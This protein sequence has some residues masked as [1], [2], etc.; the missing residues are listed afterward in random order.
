MV[1]LIGATATTPNLAAETGPKMKVV[2][3]T[4]DLGALAKEVGGDRVE[5]E[6]L[7]SGNQDP[8]FAQAKPTYLLK[9]RQAD[10]LLVVGLQLEGAWLTE[11]HHRS[12]LMSQSGNPRI[13]PG[14]SGYFDASHYVEILRD[15]AKSL[16][17][18]IQPF[19]SQHYWLDP[20]NGRRI[21]EALAD[22]LSELRP[23]DA[24]YFAER[25]R[26]FN[27]RL[28]EAKERW[29]S[30]LRPYR[31]SKVVTYHRSWPNFLKYFQ[32]VDAGQ[33][34]PTPGIPPSR[35]HTADLIGMMKREKVKII[36]IEPYFEM[37][38]PNA[39]AR[40]TGA[41]VLVL[42]SSVGGERGVTDYFQL[43]DHD[44]AALA[45]AFRGDPLG[46]NAPAATR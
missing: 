23:S 18:D 10:L 21:A 7:V 36:L 34:E 30:Q 8:H 42:P 41:K 28:S 35:R 31:G 43:L 29:Q 24:A 20:E 39:I 40:Q 46:T 5:V 3:S 11:G 9:L 14:A 6:S 12:S 19:G 13:Q 33:I 27:Q 2:A 17:P 37:K 32:L 4:S 15:P 25:V 22:R 45:R 26:L 16:T 38:T 1:A 44:V